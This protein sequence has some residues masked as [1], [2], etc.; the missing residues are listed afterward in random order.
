VNE[1]QEPEES[2]ETLAEA[3][4]RLRNADLPE[5]IEGKLETAR[6]PFEEFDEGPRG[7]STEKSG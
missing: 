6:I 1:R 7:S 2:E 3:L 5:R 4:K